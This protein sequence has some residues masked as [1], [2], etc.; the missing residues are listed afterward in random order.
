VPPS[1]RVASP[2]PADLEAVLLDCL[3]KDPAD[4]P[5][6]ARVLEARLAA[7]SA[8]GLWT[9]ADAEAWWDRHAPAS[10][11]FRSHATE[12]EGTRLDTPADRAAAAGL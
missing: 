11:G 10:G 3:A 9:A 7:T 5:D 8:A 12:P 1:K 2:V 4:R 6:S